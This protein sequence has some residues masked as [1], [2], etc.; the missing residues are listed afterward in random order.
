M[1]KFSKTVLEASFEGHF[2]LKKPNHAFSDIGTGQAHEQ[3]NKIVKTEGGP[4]G[5]LDNEKTL[6]QWIVPGLYI[7]EIE[8]FY[9]K[10]QLWKFQHISMCSCWENQG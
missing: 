8:D 6:L 1:K 10:K 2:T 9:V 4:K 7:A 3:N 5:I